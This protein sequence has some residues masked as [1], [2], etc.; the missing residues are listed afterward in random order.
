MVLLIIPS[1]QTSSFLGGSDGM[2][3][4]HQPGK[5]EMRP[6]LSTQTD[7]TSTEGFL[8]EISQ[9]QEN[10]RSIN[11]NVQR[12]QTY[13]SAMLQTADAS[14]LQRHRV[15]VDELTEDTQR[16]MAHVKQK[17]K[18]IQPTSKHTDLAIHKN[19][20]ASVTKSFMDAIERHRQVSL[21]FQ[22][23]ESRQMERQIKIANPQATPQE[24]ETAIAQAEQG[25]PAVFAQQLMQSMNNEQ[26]RYQAQET[27]DAVQERHED[28]KRL[29]KSIQELSE[30]FNEMQYLLEN[31]AHVLD[32]IEA[33]SYDV[34][35]HLEQGNQHVSNAIKSAKA[36]RRKKWICFSIFAVIII[37]VVIVVAVEVA[38]KSGGGGGGGN[39]QQ[40][41]G[42]QDQ[43]Q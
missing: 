16:T 19:Q 33:S 23:A 42:E 28:I 1:R 21:D 41:Q 20:F 24:I 8:N 7:V 15:A 3:P 10:I 4:S 26:R 25:R 9:I 29:A 2:N 30:M 36:T 32:T 17:L 27:L 38:P 5:Y 18:E 35:N 31:Q 11:D 34:V 12:I 14:E 37:I 40:Q 43:Q 13:Q 22:R 6:L 39:G